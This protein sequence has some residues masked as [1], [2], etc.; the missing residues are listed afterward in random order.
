MTVLMDPSRFVRRKVARADHCGIGNRRFAMG[1]AGKDAVA[2]FLI[3]VP[4]ASTFG[5]EKEGQVAVAKGKVQG[6][7]IGL[8]GH[9]QRLD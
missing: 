7:V 3:G 4:T 1:R 6:G 2:V 8:A 9:V 5:G